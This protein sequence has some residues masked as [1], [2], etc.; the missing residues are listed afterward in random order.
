M[1]RIGVLMGLPATDPE[2][3]RRLMAFRQGLQELGWTEGRNVRID[4]RWEGD[5][6][7]LRQYAAE[8]IALDPDV[9]LAIGSTTLGPLQRTT[10]TVPIVFALVADPVGG[11][12]VEGLA[13]PGGNATGFTLFEYSISGKWLQL[14][15]EIAPRM[16]RAAFLRDHA[17]PSGIGQFA[18]LQSAASSIG[19]EVSPTNVRD[20]DEIERSIATFARSSNGGLI[21][22]T[23]S[24]A[25]VHRELILELA[26]RHKLPAIFW[27]RFYVS[28]GGLISLRS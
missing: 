28:G 6:D 2:S 7:R 3:S 10:R 16:T 11:G 24:V 19:V 23:T 26:A 20:A 8:L 21:V 1:R 14:L 12:F 15:K 5:A 22:T 4:A 27:D 18:A 17:S 13:R 25:I 9:I